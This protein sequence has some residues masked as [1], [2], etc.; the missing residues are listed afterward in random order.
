MITNLNPEDGDSMASETF[1]S[2]RLTTRRNPKNYNFPSLSC[3]QQP[4][5]VSGLRQTM[6]VHILTPYLRPI[7]ILPSH[8]GLGLPNGN[9]L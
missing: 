1:V 6:Q 8:L 7:L 4:A 5:T 2:S 9:F 3:S